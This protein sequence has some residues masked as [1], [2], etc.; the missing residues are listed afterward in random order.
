[1]VV[2]ETVF[3]QPREVRPETLAETIDR[4]AYGQMAHMAMPQRS[5]VLQ[6]VGAGP[7]YQAIDANAL[8]EQ[9]HEG[10]V[11]RK[12][13]PER[14]DE[15]LA[16]QREV[17]GV[18][19]IAQSS[20]VEV[21]I[22]QDDGGFRVLPPVVGAEGVRQPEGVS[23]GADEL[24]RAQA[25][26]CMIKER[27]PDIELLHIDAIQVAQ[28]IVRWLEER[29]LIALEV[30]RDRKRQDGQ[31][32]QTERM[33][34]LDP[35]IDVTVLFHPDTFFGVQG[36]TLIALSLTAWPRASTAHT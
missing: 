22:R 20:G 31:R 18:V 33:E 1:M 32:L 23:L 4:I 8:R 21:Q 14:I 26:D 5:G 25:F 11:S 24:A 27:T 3:L 19:E 34:K 2:G 9:R 35:D 13:H 28:L 12:S 30:H 7:A 6:K 10:R 29:P 16:T 36:M 15:I 17:P